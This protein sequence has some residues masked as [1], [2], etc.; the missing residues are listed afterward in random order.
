MRKT[1]IIFLL[2]LILAAPSV[3]QQNAPPAPGVAQNLDEMFRRKARLEKAVWPWADLTK[4][5]AR[6]DWQ[7]E[8]L[9][10]TDA[11]TGREVWRMTSTPNI[12]NYYHNDIAMSPWSA[13]GRRLA[14]QSWRAERT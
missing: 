12:R 9:C 6:L 2:P 1:A 8:T 7:P 10:F 14:F 4:A 5:W 11:R 13:N 3:A